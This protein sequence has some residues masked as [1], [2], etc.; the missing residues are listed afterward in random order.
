[1]RARYVL[2][3][4]LLASAGLGLWA[5][6]L[7]TR[8][9]KIIAKSTLDQVGTP[10]F[11]LKAEIAPTYA[12]NKDSGQTGTVEI[13]WE[14]PERWRREVHSPV[15][16][17]VE[18]VDGAKVWQKNEGDYF[19]E[20]LREVAVAL[21]DPV[22]EPTEVFEH[23]KTA[24]VKQA[25]GQTHASW[26][27]ETSAGERRIALYGNLTITESSGL[28]EGANGT[29]WNAYLK[30]FT[31][32]HK[33][34]IARSVESGSVTAKIAVL[35]DLG[36]APAGW[37]DANAAGGDATPIETVV[38]DEEAMRRNLLPMQSVVWPDLPAGPLQGAVTA[39]VMVDRGGMVRSV[40][41]V[42]AD[43]PG[44][45]DA[46]RAAF[47]SM[48]FQPYLVN[49]RPMQV[50][51]R[52]TLAFD[53]K[54]PAGMEEFG[55]AK[56]FFERGRAVGFPAA[57]NHGPYLLKASFV[58]RSAS[59]AVVEGRYEDT[60]VDAT[61]W[62]REAWVDKSHL[63][64]T[65]NEDKRYFEM[66]GDE[67]RVLQM[68]LHLMEPI[69]A[70]DTF[71]E[72]DWRMRRERVDGVGTVRVA[73]GPE[74]A[75]GELE[76]GQARGFWFDGDGRL[77]RAVTQGVDLRRSDFEAFERVQVARTVLV[78]AAGG[79][80]VMKISVGSVEALST[81]PAKSAFVVKGS[82]WKRQFTDEVR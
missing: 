10:P 68:V 51:A 25:F 78:R 62:R 57:T 7:S 9:K 72:S 35:E 52:M 41:L 36:S 65:R 61:H 16:S 33:L 31:G 15:F 66:D 14:S 46:A 12:R 19:P 17:Q 73:A 69:P 60:F 13:W 82:E 74:N 34:L 37:F 64:R 63:V 56:D 77:V 45:N 38:V 67:Q 24:D 30:N 20:W 49:G 76:P 80:V 39:E 6:D 59:G 40:D 18:I 48:K 58:F 44:V 32:F 47:L 79:G 4:C 2:V 29:G 75:A 70:L 11:H 5:E 53:A 55:P 21:I 42:N 23:L 50:V 81:P 71:E 27:I 43:N 54:R 22:A 8:V 1:M 26:G 3:V 28:L